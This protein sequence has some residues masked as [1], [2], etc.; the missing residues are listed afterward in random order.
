MYLGA[1]CCKDGDIRY[2]PEYLDDDLIIQICADDRWGYICA[3][4]RSWG[5]VDATVACYQLGY[6][7]GLDLYYYKCSNILLVFQMK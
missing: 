1:T 7:A 6:I 5:I 4:R 2:D 3:R